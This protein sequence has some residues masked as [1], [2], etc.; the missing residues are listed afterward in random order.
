VPAK[1]PV[2]L[3]GCSALCHPARSAQPDNAAHPQVDQ[4]A[5][6]LSLWGSDIITTDIIAK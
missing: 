3:L 6:L 5:E 1:Q 4:P 2:V